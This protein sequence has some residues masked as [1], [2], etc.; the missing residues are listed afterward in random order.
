MNRMPRKQWDQFLAKA[1][2]GNPEAQWQVGS[3]YQDGLADTR[4]VVLVHPDAR[5][6]VGWFRKSAIAGNP[7]GQNHLGACLC[8]GRGVRRNEAEALRWFKRAFRQDHPIASNIASVYQDRGN[9]RRAMFWYRRAAA[10]GDGDALVDLGRGYYSGLGVRRD[11]N[12][13]VLCFK[14]AI[15]SEYISQAGREDAMFRLGLAFHEGRGVKKS[16]PRALRWLSQANKDDDH[17][18]ARDLIEKVTRAVT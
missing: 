3:W 4:G 1:Q 12:K 7:S 9:H 5:A 8:A 10:T 17:R 13:A 18:E 2:A 6:A 15:A 16:N 11:P 14:R